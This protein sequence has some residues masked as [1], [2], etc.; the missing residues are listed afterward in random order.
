MPRADAQ[1][2][3]VAEALERIGRTLH[4]ASFSRGLNPAQWNAL[5]YLARAEP[6]A[7]TMTGFAAHHRTTKSTASQ[8]LSALAR[9]GLVRRV[10]HLELTARGRRLLSHDPVQTLVAAMG[11][12]PADELGA[13]AR[14]VDRAA[15]LLAEHFAP[16]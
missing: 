1:P 8:T 3:A 6:A 14:A 5:R 16:R 13:L 4:A 9:K 15:R 11:R 7:R 12:L 10:A 2:L